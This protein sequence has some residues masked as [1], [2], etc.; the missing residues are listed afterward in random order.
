VPRRDAVLAALKAAKI[1]C[2]VYYP[3]PMHLQECFAPLGY[4][5]GD[6]PH[7]EVAARESMALPLYPEITLEQQQ[8]VARALARALEA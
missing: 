2:E 3:R 4:R 1:G 6:L 5:S 8:R 7:S